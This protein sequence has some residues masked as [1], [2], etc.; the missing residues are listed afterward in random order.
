[1]RGEMKGLSAYLYLWNSVLC[2]SSMQQE[3]EKAQGHC[4]D[5]WGLDTHS[6]L[7]G[8]ASPVRQALSIGALNFSSSRNMT[9]TTECNSSLARKPLH[10]HHSLDFNSVFWGELPL[11][12]RPAGENEIRLDPKTPLSRTKS[13][14]F[15]GTPQVLTRMDSGS[16]LGLKLQ[17][18]KTFSDKPSNHT[19]YYIH[20]DLRHRTSTWSTEDPYF[21]SLSSDDPCSPTLAEST[22]SL[23][24]TIS[25]VSPAEDSTAQP[26]DSTRPGFLQWHPQA[27]DNHL[28]DEVESVCQSKFKRPCVIWFYEGTFTWLF[29]LFP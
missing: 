17:V 7:T 15:E 2:S 29:C 14:S 22:A 5:V 28:L 10:K 13:T 6:R 18:D 26:S 16:T 23:H 25:L 8:G 27:Q 11:T 4:G 20:R 24:E 9:L 21:S 12:S 1:M 3:Q 19:E